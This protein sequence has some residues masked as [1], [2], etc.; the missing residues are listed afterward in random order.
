[1]ASF[2]YNQV[3]DSYSCS[4]NKLRG[5]SKAQACLN[6]IIHII[7]SVPPCEI[8]NSLLRDKRGLDIDLNLRLG[9]SLESEKSESLAENSFV[10]KEKE[11]ESNSS[12]GVE[13]VSRDGEEAEAIA[14]KTTPEVSSDI[15]DLQ[16]VEMRVEKGVERGD[17]NG[18]DVT[19]NA[20]FP[21]KRR[22]CDDSLALLIEAAEMISDDQLGSPK[23]DQKVAQSEAVKSGSNSKKNSWN[24]GDECGNGDFEDISPVVRSRRGRSQVLPYR[25]RDSVLEPLRRPQ[26]SAMVPKEKRRSSK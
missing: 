12:V 6:K 18:G 20:P 25:Y 23:Q 3:R 21:S 8:P 13:E 26:R 4:G 5:C 19:T 10:G 17:G 1:M 9:S 15:T 14:E 7:L 22:R 24:D 2:F 16:K 11:T